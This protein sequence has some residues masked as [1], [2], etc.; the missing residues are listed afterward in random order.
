LL[1]HPIRIFGFRISARENRSI[2]RIFLGSFLF[3]G[4]VRRFGG[5]FRCLTCRLSR[6]GGAAG[7]L[8]GRPR[9]DETGVAGVTMAGDWVGPVGLL[10]DA[11][12]T[13][14]R[15]AGLAAGRDLR[16]SSKMVA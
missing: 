14:G 15:A 16:G 12:L 5:F 8:G 13:S 10:A 2:R 9:H 4:V 6:L 7:G 3:F 11:S 1:A